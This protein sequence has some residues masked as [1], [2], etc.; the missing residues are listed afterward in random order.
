[1]REQDFELIEPERIAV[2]VLR[3]DDA[4][5]QVDDR[6]TFLEGNGRHLEQVLTRERLAA[7]PK[8]WLVV[9]DAD[10]SYETSLAVL[11]FFHPHL[12]KGD[13]IVVEDGIIS[14]LYP[15]S[16]PGHSSGPHLALK[17]FLAREG[18]SYEIDP[19]YCDFFGRNVTWATNGFLKR[20]S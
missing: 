6:V 13:Y 10:H 17:E 12:A 11:R 7:M 15:E 19:H 18:A 16:C 2:F 20:V 3:L 8:P 5:R 1:L 14:D 4:V 9:E